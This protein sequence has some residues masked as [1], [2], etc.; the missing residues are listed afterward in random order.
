[1]LKKDWNT[2]TMHSLSPKKTPSKRLDSE[3]I[4][5]RSPASRKPLTRLQLMHLDTTR[6]GY[7][8]LGNTPK[9]SLAGP[10]NLPIIGERQKVKS[11][12]SSNIPQK[13]E[14]LL[15]KHCQTPCGD[16]DRQP[17]TLMQNFTSAAQKVSLSPA[18][19]LPSKQKVPSRFP[20]ANRY[21]N[22]LKRDETADASP[23]KPQGYSFNQSYRFSTGISVLMRPISRFVQDRPKAPCPTHRVVT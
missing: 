11:K 23:P 18:R 4:M 9:Q 15:Y 3:K 7:A 10:H 5:L 8:T 13:S 2:A 22:N 12:L 19:L 16:Y 1:M 6:N 20:E 17:E 14:I 21:P